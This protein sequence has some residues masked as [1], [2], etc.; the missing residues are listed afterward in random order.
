MDRNVCIHGHFYQ[1]PRENAWLEFVELQDSAYPYHDWNERITRECYGPNATARILDETGRIARIVNNYASISFDFGPTLLS[2][3]EGADPPTYARILEA[4]RASQKRFSGHGSAIAQAYNHMILPLA[5]RR[6]KVTQVRWGLRD[7]EH[8]FGRKAEGMWLPETAVDLDSLDILAESGVAFT[9]LSQDQASRVRSLEGGEWTDVSGGRIDPTMPY[10]VHTPGGRTLSVFFYDGPISRAIAFEG[11]LNRGEDLANRLAGGFVDSRPW[12]QLVNVATDG[13]T[14]GHH[15]RHGEM[16]LAYA[17]QFLEDHGL[18]KVTNYGEYLARR[19]PTHEVEIRENTS[20]SCVH[21]LERWRSDCGCRTGGQ[22]EWNQAW[23]APLRAS[24]DALRDGLAPVY[25]R[26]AARLL[27]D[28][29]AARDAYI[30]VILDRSRER[31]ESFL[32]A[33]AAESLDESGRTRALRLLEM[34]RHLMLMYTSCGW[35]FNELSGIETV[36]I[37]QYADRAI[38]FAE[39][40]TGQPF[41]EDFLRHLELARSNLPGHP[42]GRTVFADRVRPSRAGLDAVAAHYAVSSLF[43]TY[44]DEARLFCYDAKRQDLAAFDGG[45]A[46]LRMGR[47][48]IV[49][50]L[51]LAGVDASFAVLLSGNHDIHGGVRPTRGDGGYQDLARDMSAAFQ[52]GDLAGVT[53]LIDAHFGPATFS[54]ANLFRDEQHKVLDQILRDTRVAVRETY[55]TLF[56]EHAPLMHFVSTPR[57]PLP[58]DLRAVAQVVINADLRELL[59]LDQPE[60]DRVQ[61]LLADA[62]TLGIELDQEGLAFTLKQTVERLAEAL[63]NRPTDPVALDR[64]TQCVRLA[65]DLP[66]E[67]DLR[68]TQNVYWE[69]LDHGI[70]KDGDP[71]GEATE[72]FRRLGADLGF[73]VG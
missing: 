54:L 56:R 40:I 37:L 63:R 65:R 16:A 73:R 19:P 43:E 72:R 28:P 17:L 49:S 71:A 47:V 32:Q 46:R 39:R 45:G 50:R 13:E 33:Q 8:R 44:P 24:L 1:P 18:A 6:D 38:G 64:L 53:Q 21:G 68:W 58:K 25:E 35:F 48:G 66:F 30:D 23:R 27:R 52:R 55:R 31:V 51:T 60:P 70:S 15:H 3:L 11:L 42:D 10:R 5:N 20:W 2:W 29:W 9:I 57:T 7:F 62:R 26:E 14:Y 69:L 67:V 4:D 61:A 41:E 22:P 36:Q 34:Q 59:A 12:P